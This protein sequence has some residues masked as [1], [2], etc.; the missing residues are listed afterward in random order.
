M[1]KISKKYF[2]KLILQRDFDEGNKV[3]DC[4]VYMEGHATATIFQPFQSRLIGSL[5]AV[6]RACFKSP[7]VCSETLKILLNPP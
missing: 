7:T 5:V 2:C 3:S 1:K 6:L 4:S